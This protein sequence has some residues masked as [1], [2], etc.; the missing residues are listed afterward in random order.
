LYVN[1]YYPLTHNT[2][3]YLISDAKDA[4]KQF[5]KPLLHA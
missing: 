5:F 1:P 3:T 2:S 4:S